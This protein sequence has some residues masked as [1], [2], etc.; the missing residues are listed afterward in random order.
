M[1]TIE[2]ARA[3]VARGAAHLD[4]VRP[5]WFNQIDVGTLTLHDPC[6][7]IVGQ[8]CG[9]Y[10]VEYIGLALRTAEE[11]RS[12]VPSAASL[13]GFDLTHGEAAP[14]RE[15][16]GLSVEAIRVET[17]KPL[18]DA[19]I[20]AIAARKFPAQEPTT[21]RTDDAVTVGATVLEP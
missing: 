10:Y 19:W 3:R 20:E 2:E 9:G 16:D 13:H 21:A 15:C 18:Q 1:L 11:I 5:G 12:G 4:S 7:C 17:Y 6:G 14:I 8:L